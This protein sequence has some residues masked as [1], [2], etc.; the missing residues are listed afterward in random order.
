FDPLIAVGGSFVLAGATAVGIGVKRLS[1]ERMEYCGLSGVCIEPAVAHESTPTTALLA[2]GIA[3]GIAG[4]TTTTVGA[5]RTHRGIVSSTRTALGGWL[6]GV[7]GSVTSVGAAVWARQDH[8][9]AETGGAVS[10]VVGL[11]TMVAGTYLVATDD[12]DELVPEPKSETEMTAGIVVATAGAALVPATILLC[13]DQGKHGEYALVGVIVF[14][15]PA[16]AATTLVS[17]GGAALWVDG[18]RPRRGSPVEV[19]F[20]V[21]PGGAYFRGAW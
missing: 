17:A 12:P 1:T 4:L 2:G 8:E 13:A 5:I 14:C 16:A 11:S 6:L 18:A 21:G 7:G 19:S 20:D 3:S 15:L 10:A 9:E